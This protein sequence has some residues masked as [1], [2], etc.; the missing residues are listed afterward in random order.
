MEQDN[1]IE[2]LKAENLCGRSG[3]GFPTGLKWEMVKNE[4]APKKYVI[5]NASEGEPGVFKDGFI[6]ENWPEEVINGIKIAISEMGAE[7]AYIYINKDYYLKFKKILEKLTVNSP[8]VI[9][10][11]TGG[12]IGGEETS[13]CNIIEG[14]LLE[15]RQKPPFPTKEG[16]FGC[17]TL[18]NNVE[19]FYCI[20]K[21]SKGEYK[22]TRFF[23]VNGDVKNPG[24]F[25]LPESY[26]MREVLND[27][28]N[29]PNF[30][31]FVQAGGGVSGAILLPDE[32]D[33]KVPGA[34]SIAVFNKTK[35]N[36]KLLMKKWVDFLLAGNCDK[37]TP[38]REGVYRIAEILDSDKIDEEL[39]GELFFALKETSFCAL[40]RGVPVP[41][42]TL[43]KKVIHGNK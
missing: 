5:C 14:N 38:C 4:K 42:E 43:I 24:V 17:P 27:S 7:K 37:C 36:A 33:Q 2:K 1:I 23:S 26:T 22:K 10:K 18:I 31:Y 25:E 28:Q 41:F 12:Y 34:G 8:I 21:I 20:S 6:L 13:A 32:L 9:F 29:L 16:L 30:D 19:T 35:T 3:S 11:K 40:G 39:L 15:P